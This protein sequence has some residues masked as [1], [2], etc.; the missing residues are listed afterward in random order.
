MIDPKMLYVFP[1][2][3]FACNLYTHTH[4]ATKVW[5]SLLKNFS[6]VSLCIWRKTGTVKIVWA[7]VLASLNLECFSPEEHMM[8]SLYVKHASYR[9]SLKKQ[10]PDI[11]YIQSRG[12]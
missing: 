7:V 6:D 1:Y 5:W 12:A 9:L 4:K 10:K 3:T 8:V 2:V 11:Y